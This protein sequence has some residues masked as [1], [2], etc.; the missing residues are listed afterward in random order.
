MRIHSQITEGPGYCT[1]Y[2][3]TPRELFQVRSMISDQYLQ[4]MREMVP[5]LADQAASLG[6]E[7]YHKLPIDFDHAST[8]T[9]FKRILD[10]G[11]VDELRKMEFFRTIE[12]QY[13]PVLVSD[14]ELNWRLVRPNFPDDVGPVH[15]DK[16]FWDLGYGTLPQ[17]HGR[18][19]IWVP[20]F[21]EPGRNGLSVKPCS[22][23]TD[24]WKWHTDV[25]GGMAK[26]VLDENVAELNMQLLNLVPGEMVMFHD[27][28]LHGGVVNRGQKCRVSIE[29]TIFYRE[30]LASEGMRRWKDSLRSVQAQ[31]A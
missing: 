11:C 31:V 28:L 7:N 5:R 19:K 29:L 15:A 3:L 27:W 1:E 13:G 18:Y 12:E 26:P 30:D 4:R 14:E 8:W 22:H 6:I 20:V 17:G 16:W 25:K 10:P 2:R 24:K 21:S 9:K 23:L